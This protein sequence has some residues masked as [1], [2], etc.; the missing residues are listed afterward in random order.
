MNRWIKKV[1]D[2]GPSPSAL[3][4]PIRAFRDYYVTRVGGFSGELEPGEI[5]I[6]RAALEKNTDIE[7]YEDLVTVAKFD[8][9]RRIPLV[10]RALFYVVPLERGSDA[11]ARS[12][13]GEAVLRAPEE[14]SPEP[15]QLDLEPGDSI[16]INA[17]MAGFGVTRSSFWGGAGP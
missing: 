14:T 15:R 13:S 4:F 3:P 5:G 6:N 1:D 17:F 12:P 16:A 8:S 11:Y 7:P 2:L 10:I 9:A